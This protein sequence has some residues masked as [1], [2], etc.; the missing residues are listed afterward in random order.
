MSKAGADGLRA[1]ALRVIAREGVAR[2]TVRAI[3]AEAGVTEP[4]LYRHFPS[5]PALFADL[6]R[7]CARKLYDYLQKAIQSA[8]GPEQ[9]V[10]ALAA[11]L[12]DFAREYPE[13]YALILAAHQQQ[14]K[15][16][17]TDV[18]PLPKDLFVRAVRRLQEQEAESLGCTGGRLPAELA[19][20]TI[21]GATMGVVLLWRLGHV[22]A[23]GEAC[24]EHVMRTAL[25]AA[26]AA[27][28]SA[29]LPDAPASTD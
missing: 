28:G 17:D 13:E 6:F 26:R 11:G 10:A 20:A 22:P 8:A 12:F 25:C 3:A 14:L 21:I 4:A 1:A 27:C 24:R 19:A 7:D 23:S 15:D 18:H 2:T 9:E 16:L 5:K 29:T